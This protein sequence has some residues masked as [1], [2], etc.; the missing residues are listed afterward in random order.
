[1]A[2]LGNTEVG[3]VEADIDSYGVDHT[4]LCSKATL[5]TCNYE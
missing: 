5:D 2:C 1:M 4:H 3:S